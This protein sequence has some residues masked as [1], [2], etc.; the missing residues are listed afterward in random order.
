MQRKVFT[1]FFSIEKVPYTVIVLNNCNEGNCE[2]FSITFVKTLLF[3]SKITKSKTCVNE[4][5][6]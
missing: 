5:D 4:S 1:L 3:L 2:K 6:D